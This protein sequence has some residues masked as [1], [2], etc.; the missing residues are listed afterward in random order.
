MSF[1]NS[2]PAVGSTHWETEMLVQINQIR[3]ERNLKP[4]I[5]C[6]ALTRSAQKYAEE[7]ARMNFFSHTG[8]DGSQPGDRIQKA[9]YRWK[10]STAEATVAENI[11]A[12]QI[13]V[14][15]V[16]R[17]WRMS[18]G[19]YKNLVNPKFIHVGFGK[20]VNRKSDIPGA[21]LRTTYSA[22]DAN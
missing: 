19:H 12:G 6:S 16:M 21:I 8:K 5:L 7:M 1:I 4:L 20:T 10:N 11:A 15:E 18:R 13:S 14:S 22:A 9:G 3:A 2:L 17:S